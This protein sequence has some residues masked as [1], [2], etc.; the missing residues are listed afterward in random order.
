VT[1]LGMYSAERHVVFN[2]CCKLVDKSSTGTAGVWAGDAA[3][4]R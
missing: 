4:A 2:H 3:S 1:W